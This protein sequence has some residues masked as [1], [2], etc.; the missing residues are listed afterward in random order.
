MHKD[1][2]KKKRHVVAWLRKTL[3]LS[4]SEFAS[5]INSSQPTIQAVE[6]GR[7]PLSERFALAI[8]S[9]T[10][11]SAKWLLQNKLHPLPDAEETREKYEHAKLGWSRYAAVPYIL[12]RM[13]LMRT[14]IGLRMIAD[15]LGYSGCKAAGYFARLDK[16]FSELL[17]AIADLP[18]RRRVYRQIS[19]I[20]TDNKKT[21][22][23]L[24]N[25]VREMAWALKQYQEQ[26][27][28]DEEMEKTQREK[29]KLSRA[30]RNP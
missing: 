24:S 29:E 7:I 17:K 8:E 5:L 14:Y 18:T 21:L 11:T 16:T 30:R 1:Q 15:E 19:E 3:D 12:P 26:T 4:Q 23:L 10:G 22:N 27:R 20:T 9:K 6:L 2:S 13:Y 28:E 25:D